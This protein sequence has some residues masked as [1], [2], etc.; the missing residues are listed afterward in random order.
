MR[1]DLKVV[2]CELGTLKA[3]GNTVAK[4]VLRASRPPTAG[5]VHWLLQWDVSGSMAWALNQVKRDLQAFIGTLNPADLASIIIFS[6]HDQA[7]LLAGPLVCDARGKKQLVEEIG[8]VHTLSNTVFSEGL[9]RVIE[10]VENAGGLQH[11]LM[12]FTDGCPVP[13]RWSEA[14]EVAQSVE[15]AQTLGLSHDASL[16]TLGYG[17]YYNASFLADLVRKNGGTGV[18]RH[19]NDIGLFGPVISDILAT[20]RATSFVDAQLSFTGGKGKPG[21]VLRATPQVD[22]VGDNGVATLRSLHDGEVTLFVVLPTGTTSLTMSGK[23]NGEAF[24]AE[25]ITTKALSEGGALDASLAFASWAFQT[26][27][28][29]ASSKIL[30][31]AGQNMLGMMAG[32]AY[33]DRER[34]EVGDQLRRIIIDTGIRQRYSTKKFIGAGEA[35]CVVN[36][37]R[38]LLEEDCTV[39]IPRGTYQKTTATVIEKGVRPKPNAKIKMTEIQSNQ[40]RFNFSMKTEVDVEEQDE[41]TGKWVDGQRF[42][43][44]VIIKDGSLHQDTLEAYLTKKAFEL[45]QKWGV[46]ADNLRFSETK[47]FT[48]DLTVLPMIVSSWA[49]PKGLGLIDLMKEEIMLEAEQKAINARVKALR[50]STGT[51][52]SYPERTKVEASDSYAAAASKYELKGFKV[53]ATPD[54]SRVTALEEAEEKAKAVRKRL[55]VVRC[56]KRLI[57]FA[58]EKSGNK[59]FQGITPTPVKNSKTGKM[60]QTVSLASLGEP[61]LSLRRVSWAE[62]VPVSSTADIEEALAV[63]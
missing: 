50:V 57:L 53:A 21:M 33:T 42:R 31:E 58:M 59:L 29:V 20:G 62:I 35:A 15:H 52:P 9:E 41:D 8:A 26:G 12:L 36:L 32:S 13:S 3:T 1:N 25:P 56:I 28:L 23:V 16:S 19:I 7:K 27:D 38:V 61:S 49:N 55:L 48:L 22:R 18:N 17:N 24:D 43:N 5:P 51:A 30:Q 10:S 39:F 4:V 44:Y 37:L 45:C 40:E 2:S 47:L 46:I 60:E 14:E 11:H 6:G 63:A 54:F 34:L